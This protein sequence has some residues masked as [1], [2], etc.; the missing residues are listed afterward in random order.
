M[1]REIQ[2]R[3]SVS[4]PLEQSTLYTSYKSELYVRVS[5][6]AEITVFKMMRESNHC[7]TAKSDM[8]WQSLAQY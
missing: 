3:E 4:Q 7:V 8:S 2:F 6:S 1:G 5:L